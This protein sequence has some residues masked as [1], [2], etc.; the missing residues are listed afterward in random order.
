MTKLREAQIMIHARKVLD[1]KNKITVSDLY[2][3][4]M[5]KRAANAARA[6]IKGTSV[7]LGT[8]HVGQEFVN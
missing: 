4:R 2:P 7:D 6:T 3:K 5:M 1:P 8:F